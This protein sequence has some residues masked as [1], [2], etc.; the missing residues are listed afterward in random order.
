MFKVS[1]FMSINIVQLFGRT[2]PKN[3]K[4]V[5]AIKKGKK[6]EVMFVYYNESRCPRDLQSPD[7]IEH[8]PQQ[9]FETFLIR[10]L[11]PY[12]CGTDDAHLVLTS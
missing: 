11:S 8:A 5:I 10:W 9:S 1:K 2:I 7:C 3:A 6:G 4:I 12:S